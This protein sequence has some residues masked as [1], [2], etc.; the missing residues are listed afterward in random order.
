ML[1]FLPA[2]KPS[3]SYGFTTTVAATVATLSLFMVTTGSVRRPGPDGDMGARYQRVR[4]LLPLLPGKTSRVS[5]ERLQWVATDFVPAPTF[6][7]PGDFRILEKRRGRTTPGEAAVLSPAAIDVPDFGA[8]TRVYVESE[9]D[10]PVVRDA[11]SAAPEYPAS[12]EKDGIEGYVVVQF[13]VD[14]L[15]RADTASFHIISVSHIA[16]AD[17]VL[18]ALPGMRFSPAELGGHHVPQRVTQSFKF[19]I[20]QAVAAARATSAASGGGPNARRQ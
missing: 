19:V 9:L 20:P 6:T 4:Y 10:R 7:Y 1:A 8:P 3:G 17:A 12:L 15:G 14:T 18:A 5:Y 16:F 2:S 11:S 13:D